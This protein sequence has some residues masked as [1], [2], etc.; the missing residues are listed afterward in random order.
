[1]ST[2]Y[3]GIIT[4]EVRKRKQVGTSTL[5][6]SKITPNLRGVGQLG[7][8]RRSAPAQFLQNIFGGGVGPRF[9]RYGI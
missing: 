6:F 3:A 7:V 4:K 5:Q 1:M 9:I 8:F 2:A